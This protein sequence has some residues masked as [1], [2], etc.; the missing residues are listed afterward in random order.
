[1]KEKRKKW[2]KVFKAKVVIKIN[3]MAQERNLEGSH[4]RFGAGLFEE[5][6]EK[7]SLSA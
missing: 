6:A 1:M 3:A 4:T 7:Q 5:K 2:R